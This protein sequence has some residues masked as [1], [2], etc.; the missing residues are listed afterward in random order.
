MKPGAFI[1]NVSRPGVIDRAALIE[2]LKSGR[3][4]GFALD[5]LYEAPG[6]DDDELLQ[7]KNVILTP[8]LAAQPRL[9]CARR[10]RRHRRRHG[11]R[12][13]KVRQRLTYVVIAPSPRACGERARRSSTMQD[14]VRGFAQIRRMP[15]TRCLPCCNIFMPL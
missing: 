1:V 6:R 14:W 13:D 5:P 7:F 4:G 9:E 2:A 8:H 12:V 10:F 11:A 3:L 15:L